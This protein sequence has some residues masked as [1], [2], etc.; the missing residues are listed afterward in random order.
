MSP[1]STRTVRLSLTKALVESQQWAVDSF[2]IIIDRAT[3]YNERWRL[4]SQ[5]TSEDSGTQTW[6]YEVLGVPE[7]DLVVDHIIHELTDAVLLSEWHSVIEDSF[8]FGSM[9]RDHP[10]KL[11][12]TVK[13]EEIRPSTQIS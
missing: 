7:I 10:E 5:T 8:T 1:P 11:Q 13:D 2:P 9:R 12:T 3:G 4:I 6:H